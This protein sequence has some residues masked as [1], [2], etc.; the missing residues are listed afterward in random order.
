M[1]NIRELVVANIIIAENLNSE[2]EKAVT[3]LENRLDCCPKQWE[4]QTR[5]LI[6]NVRS[7]ID[8]R[9]DCINKLRKLND[10]YLYKDTDINKVDFEEIIKELENLDNKD[11]LATNIYNSVMDE[12]I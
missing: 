4:F 2:K 12:E 6:K 1:S 3:K 11:I 9:N 10:D 8:K 7:N 5:K